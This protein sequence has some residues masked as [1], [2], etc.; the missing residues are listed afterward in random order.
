[1]KQLIAFG[2]ISRLKQLTAFCDG[3]NKDL[4]FQNSF[5]NDGKW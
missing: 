1:M 3:T 4:A 5:V 2:A